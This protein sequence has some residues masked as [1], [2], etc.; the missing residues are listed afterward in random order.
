MNLELTLSDIAALESD[1]MY[2]ESAEEEVFVEKIGFAVGTAQNICAA[3]AH[4][5]SM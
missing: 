5:M 1:V 2:V 4:N 3:S